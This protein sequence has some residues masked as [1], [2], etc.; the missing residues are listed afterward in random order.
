[1][2]SPA[3]PS[4]PTDLPPTAWKAVLRRTV[5]EFQA[6]GLSDWAAALT[7]YGVLSIFPALIA[8]VS[9]V[10]L[11]GQSATDTLLTNL[12]SLTPGPAKDIVVNAIHGLQGNTGT[13]GVLLVVGI[14]GAVWSASGYVAAFMRAANIVFD[15]P[16]GRPIWKTLP[17]RVGVTVALLVTLA[18]SAVGVVATGD[19]ARQV[20]DVVGLSSEAVSAF[21]IAKWPILVLLVSFMFGLLYWAAPNAKPGF[22]WI[23]PGSLLAVLA[24]IAASALFALYLANFASYNKTYGT[25][26][27]IIAFLVWLWISNLA[28]LL[29][30]EL[31]AELQRGRNIA[32]GHF[33]GEEPYVELRDTQTLAPNDP[34]RRET[35]P[36]PRPTAPG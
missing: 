25:L 28:L 12:E 1:M 14:A 4:G 5:K 18:V 27:G 7:Y 11:L 2:P 6:D 23:T 3:G 16:E 15:V 36:S 19:V 34:A 31:N 29:G 24:W 32:T 13:A 35:S 30:A 33:A 8:L 26:G 9:V 17:V 22:R 10:G 21:E 20:G